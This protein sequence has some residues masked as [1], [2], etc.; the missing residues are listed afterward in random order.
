MAAIPY[1]VLYL[2][3]ATISGLLAAYMWR[4]RYYRSGRSF[5]LLMGALSF[6]C[7]C[8]ALSIAGP[9]F[10]RTYFWSSVQ[11]A[12]IVM[13]MPAW[14]M[15]ALSYT[16]YWWRRN[17]ALLAP[18]LLPALVFF[19]LM[20]TN[21]VHGQW[22]TRV[23]PD[24]SR[25]FM[26]L[27]VER[28][29]MFW[30]HSLYAYSCFLAATV[31]LAI[32]ALRAPQAERR[33]SWLMLSASL[34]SAVGNL[35]FITGIFKPWNDDPTPLFLLAS[36]LIAFYATVHFRVIDLNPLVERA[37]LEALP[38]GMVVLDNQQLVAEINSM[39]AELLGLAPDAAAAR[40]FA[41]L[42]VYSPLGNAIRP[43][44]SGLNQLTGPRTHFVSFA[45]LEGPRTIE[46]RLRP[47]LAANG[48]IAGTLLLLRDVSERA[49][50]EQASA[51][52]LAELSLL[53]RVARAANTAADSAELIR[54]AA[55]TI[56]EAGIWERVAVG[57]LDR[58]GDR[59]SVAADVFT[60]TDASYEGQLIEGAEGAALLRLL[61]A[62]QSRVLDLDEPESVPAPLGVALRNEGLR[63][64]MVVPL[65]LGDTDLGLLVL[66]NLASGLESPA[67]LRVAE[68]MG[69][70]I[71]D[72]VVRAQL[73]EEVRQADQLKSSFIASVSHELRTPLT[74][75][76]G[77]IDMIQKGIYG[78]PDERMHEPLVYMRL[79]SNTLLRMITDVLDFSRM[80]AGHLKVDLQ[81]V[82]VARSVTN[83]IG[84][85]QPQ[86]R[87]RPIELQVE[88]APNLPLA[89]ANGAR[90]EQVLVNLFSNALKFTEEGRI[91]VRAGCTGR[92]LQLSVQ[93]SGIGI[94]AEHVDMI[95]EEFR[96]V[97]TPGRRIGG[98][99]LGLAISRRLVEL[100]GGTIGVESA[101]G[102]GST[103]TIE[104]ALFHAAERGD[105]LDAIKAFSMERT[106]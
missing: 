44:L 24:T 90:L 71:T 6:W 62:G 13:I 15:L 91:T 74:S 26:W 11:Y 27:R 37:A 105:E 48:A 17:L 18:L 16:G 98:A 64:L 28:G 36:G 79:S 1:L 2:V 54:A 80:E 69:E 8:H 100:M 68:T 12:G 38:D 97:E 63:R 29:W 9:T 59:L 39:G 22:W 85:L 66:G 50:A 35:A 10:E 89:Y 106:V 83:V 77:Y 34:L 67:L 96:R 88:F 14:L 47:L 95:F 51:R 76:M 82:D 31:L 57:L 41:E 101:L 78:K 75:I 33:Q 21:G 23:E 87:D 92:R 53:N 104:L 86:L 30:A 20:L 43:V 52:H 58:G 56:A 40:P 94:A 45:A 70:L 84:Q 3:P 5:T 81:P 103:F 61:R 93:D 55:Q 102:N 99:G 65:R 72:A 32:R 60:E 4:R 46:L 19:V 7:F 49:Q 25:G 42:L 73:Y